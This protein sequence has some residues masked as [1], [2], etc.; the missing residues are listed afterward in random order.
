MKILFTCNEFPPF[1][2]GGQGIFVHEIS[3]QLANMDHTVLVYGVY[4]SINTRIKEYVNNVLII[5]DPL[6]YSETSL[7]NMLKNR[8]AYARA[9]NILSK[10]NNI[11]I[12]EAHDTGG[13]FLFFRNSRSLF[14]RLHNGERYFKKRGLRILLIERISF[15]LKPAYIIAISEFILKRFKKYFIVLNPL[16]KYSIIHNGIYIKT[17]ELPK[18]IVKKIVFAG[19]LKKI[20]GIDVLIQGFISSEIMKEGYTLEI[21]GKDTEIAESLTY[22]DYLLDTI[23]NLSNYV[24]SGI[25]RYHGP[26]KTDYLLNAFAESEICVFPS[27][28]ESFGLVVIEAMSVGAITIYTK[29]GAA[30]EIIDDGAEGFL[31]EINNHQALSKKIVEVIGLPESQKKVIRQNAKRKAMLFSIEKCA[32]KTLELYNAEH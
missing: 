6:K 24:K 12:I 20:K 11:D 16:N 18:N 19:T 4:P 2:Y 8:I 30:T 25:I 27:H 3:R 10:S 26:V 32:N 29:Q 1:T 7:V 9:I 22:W 21:Y 17:V 15:L 23:E 5:R 31:V 13:W 28:L 14:I